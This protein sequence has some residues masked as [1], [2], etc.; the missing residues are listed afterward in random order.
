MCLLQE[1][2]KN[3]SD[4]EEKMKWPG[5]FPHPIFW[6]YGQGRFQVRY[7]NYVYYWF[8]LWRFAFLYR[9]NYED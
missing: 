8:R 6:R 1:R 4:E 9:I 3:G 2:Q 5:I 7:G